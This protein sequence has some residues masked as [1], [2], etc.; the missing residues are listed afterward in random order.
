MQMK[1]LRRKKVRKR[2]SKKDRQGRKKNTKC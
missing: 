2:E 1:G